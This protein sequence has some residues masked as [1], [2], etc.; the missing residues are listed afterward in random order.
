MSFFKREDKKRSD[1]E[2]SLFDQRKRSL[3]DL[4]IENSSSDSEDSLTQWLRIARAD[5]KGYEADTE[6]YHDKIKIR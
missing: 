1:S 5:P 2:D 3:S 4:S 6:D